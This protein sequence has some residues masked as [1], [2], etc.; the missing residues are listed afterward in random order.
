MKKTDTRCGALGPKPQGWLLARYP[1]CNRPIGHKDIHT[2][3]DCRYGTVLYHWDE[4][5][6]LD[7]TALR[8]YWN[9]HNKARSS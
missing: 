8:R 2:D 1:R 7:D 5:L 4:P 6:V 9:S 3:T